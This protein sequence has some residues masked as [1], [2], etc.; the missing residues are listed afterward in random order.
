GPIAGQDYP[1]A[2]MVGQGVIG[3]VAASGRAIIAN[4]ESTPNGHSEH[5]L[6]VPLVTF[7]EIMGVMVVS[8]LHKTPFGEDDLRFF[9]SIVRQVAAAIYSARRFEE[10]RTNLNELA[11]LY[12]TSSAISSARDTEAVLKTL[13]RQMVQIINASSGRMY[14]WDK[15]LNTGSVQAEFLSEEATPKEVETE[16]I[17]RLGQRPILQVMR[18]QQPAVFQ[19]SNPALDEVE[20]AEMARCGC[21]SRLL[22]PLVVKGAAI[23]WVEL[24]ETRRE[25]SFTADEIRLARLLANQAAVALENVQYLRQLQQALEESDALYQVASTLAS[26]Q[27]SH[28]IMSIV[29]Q[30]YL[31]ALNL[32]QGSVVIF[33]FETKKGVVKVSQQDDAPAR[34]KRTEPAYEG[35]LRPVQGLEGWQFE[36]RNN[37][38]YEQLMSTHWPVVIEDVQTAPLP[39]NIKKK[40]GAATSSLIELGWVGPETLS[41]L[42]IPIQVRGEISGAILIEATRQKRLFSSGEISLGQAMA[43][44]LGVGLQSVELYEAELQRRQQAETLREVSSVVGSSLNLN[45]VLER[46][47]DQL[48]R[49]VKY[50]SAAIHLI[51]GKRRRIIAGRGFPNPKKVVGLTFPVNLDNEQDP[52]MVA[53][54]RHQPLIAHNIPPS[55]NTL[56]K[57]NEQI[58]S[59][60]GIPLIARD[61][62][63]GLISIDHTQANAYD[64]DDLQLALAFA[65]QV[66]IALENARLYE[67][68]VRELER[69]LE[70]AHTIQ[71]TLLPQI[72]PQI[73]GLQI[74]GRILPARQ[75]G[76]D[77]FHFFAIN[78]DQL[79]VAIGDVSGKGIPAAL[80][81]AVAITAIDA[82]IQADIGPGKLLNRLN[83]ILY[84]RLREN[85]MN[86]GLQVAHFAPLP[87][88]KD[89]DGKPLEQ[90]RGMLMTVAS[91][92]MIAPIGATKHGLRYLPVGGLPVGSLAPP[93]EVYQDDVF[94]LDPFTTVIFTS[95]GIVEAQNET[96]ELFGFERLEQAIA[97]IIETQ[98][99]E[100]IAEH[101][102]NTAQEFIGQA[103]QNDD[104]TV[105]VV[106]KT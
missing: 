95:D 57:S 68:E 3:S 87:A 2:L 75:I 14:S 84:N 9:E 74:S 106:V 43:D 12:E 7:K 41:L 18:G 4:A 53:I 93:E 44:Q 91:G 73:E 22:V 69:E 11:I 66:A 67:L 48:A 21:L 52:G 59:W 55:Y 86:I 65:N 47:L 30:E 98:D 103:E 82:Q 10:T 71:E 29:L 34:W 56:K 8:R 81:M 100:Q 85:K 99:A 78:Q 20:L 62:V 89:G 92:G 88:P 17:F 96:R 54:Q 102:I 5:M 19:V 28:A 77:F 90:P 25:R 49:V 50:H 70:I 58:K 23:G 37:P 104:M 35:L 42:V 46:I 32:Y 79:G 40:S 27:D 15:D 24:W 61:K 72:V 64:E 33:D 60:M 94:L 38:V 36:L 97:D 6:C 39:V 16:P 1:T 26:T 13:I 83:H 31:R 76:G 101:I 45:E 51:E 80:Y 63:I 105:V